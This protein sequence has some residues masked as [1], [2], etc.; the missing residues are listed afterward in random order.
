MNETTSKAHRPNYTLAN[1]DWRVCGLNP[2]VTR[3]EEFVR[4]THSFEKTLMA[5]SESDSE[6]DRLD[7]RT[8]MGTLTGIA[9]DHGI[10][11]TDDPVE[12]LR[13]A[14]KSE[15]LSNQSVL[16]MLGSLIDYFGI[17]EEHRPALERV[18][19]T[20]ISMFERHG[21]LKVDRAEL[22]GRSVISGFY[23]IGNNMDLPLDHVLASE[24]CP[25]LSERRPG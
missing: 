7:F 8:V 1:G 2:R 6:R 5:L 14:S 20:L 13:L 12:R 24:R 19:D 11:F 21:M 15:M 3:S 9:A 16:E 17:G 18:Q 25:F 23:C 4:L 22:N 10:K